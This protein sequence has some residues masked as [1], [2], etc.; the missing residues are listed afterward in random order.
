MFRSPHS[1][2]QLN[3]KK[4]KFSPFITICPN[5]TFIDKHTIS[6]LWWSELDKAYAYSSMFIEI[7]N[8]QNNHPTI[9]IKQAMK[10]LYQPNNLTHYDASNFIEY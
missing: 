5:D 6:N 8:L 4:V 2:H 10:L 7:K 1:L 9:T 3:I